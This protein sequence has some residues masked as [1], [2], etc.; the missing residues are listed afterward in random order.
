M[1]ISEASYIVGT[2]FLG[3][4]V[5]IYAAGGDPHR[6]EFMAWDPVAG[7]KVW[8]ENFPDWSGTIVTA[9]NVAFHRTM[10]R[11]LFKAVNACTGEVV[12]KMRTPSGIIASRPP[13]WARTGGST[14]PSAPAWAAGPALWRFTEIGPR[15][16][17]GALEL[18]GAI[19]DLPAHTMGGGVTADA[20]VRRAGGGETDVAAAWGP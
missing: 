17:N 8:S 19:Q 5:N 2:P 6:G 20:P 12:W 1:A 7:E 11:W 13:T 18:V 4:Q 16:P 9:G 3:A 14:S 10:D 15:V